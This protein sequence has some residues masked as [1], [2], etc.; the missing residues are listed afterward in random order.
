M[1]GVTSGRLG[2]ASRFC[3][4]LFV[5]FV[6]DAVKKKAFSI[7]FVIGELGDLEPFLHGFR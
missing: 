1:C 6:C 4:L 7:H 2:E 5:S 3:C